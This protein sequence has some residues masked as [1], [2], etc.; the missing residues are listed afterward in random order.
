MRQAIRVL[1][2]SP[3]FTLVAILSLALGIG[4]NTAIFTL[5][6]Q[7]LLRALP[8]KA[9]EQLDLL[10]FTGADSG[11][12]RSRD[13]GQLYFSY[14]MYRDLRD[15]NTVFEGMLATFSLDIAVNARGQTEH[16][17]GELVS[18]NYFEMLGVRPAL[19]RLFQQSDDVTPDANPVAVL[20]YGYWQRHFGGDPS[21]LN[22]TIRV[23]EH[24]FTVVG[25]G[26]PGFRS[27]VVGDSPD[28]FVPNVLSSCRTVPR[29]PLTSVD[30]PSC[31]SDNASLKPTTQGF[32]SSRATIAA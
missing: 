1:V 25:V 16:A 7:V 8:A 15:R 5:L 14:P 13:D 23:N 4:A 3:S 26:A 22:Q 32:P 28:V 2:K 18:G 11:S 21:I 29:L 9:P 31:R 30:T 24:P 17:Q 27:V 12:L 6:D 10:R 20:S 19:G